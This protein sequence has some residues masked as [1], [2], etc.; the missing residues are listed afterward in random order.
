AASPTDSSAGASPAGW[1]DVRLG[2]VA[3]TEPA[4]IS[5]NAAT[6]SG[7]S[8]SPHTAPPRAS[9]SAGVTY[10]DTTAAGGPTSATRLK[11]SRSARAVQMTPR[12]ASEPSTCA[13]GTV[14]GQVRAAAGA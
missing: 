10:A 3:S 9:A 4:R 5:T 13:D 2:R 8:G 7:V 11:H 14:A 12:A 1:D 6:I